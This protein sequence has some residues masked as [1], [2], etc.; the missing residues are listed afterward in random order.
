MFD[1][2]PPCPGDPND[3]VWVRSKEGPHWRRK[4]GRVTA[5]HLN[6]S[7][8]ESNDQTKIVSPAASRA[9]KAVAPY[10]GGI[11][12]GRLNNRIS[13]AFRKS[14]KEKGQLAFHYLKGIEMQRE[15]PLDGLLKCDYRLSVTEKSIT[16]TIPVARGSV[17]ALNKLVTD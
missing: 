16:I 9:R 15:H 3:Y 2:R 7:Y 14:L 4:R 10:L 8:Q 17:Q 6:G 12:A 1:K 5:A 13:T 11:T